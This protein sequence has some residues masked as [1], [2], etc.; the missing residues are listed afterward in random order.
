MALAQIRRAGTRGTDLESIYSATAR[1]WPSLH[2]SPWRVKENTESE[3]YVVVQDNDQTLAY[4]YFEREV[5]RQATMKRIGKGDAHQHAR[6]ISRIPRMLQ[7]GSPK[8][9][10]NAT[11]ATTSMAIIKTKS[12]RRA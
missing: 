2:P 9:A 4:V 7:R 10:N 3:S 6:A 11:P 1:R 12:A 8:T 5:V